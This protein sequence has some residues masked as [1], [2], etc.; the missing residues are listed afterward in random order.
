MTD[1]LNP[2]FAV[3][4]AAL[5]IF[6]WAYGQNVDD[7]TMLGA[8]IGGFNLA[9]GFYLGSTSSSGKSTENV[10]KAFDALKAQTDALSSGP[11]GAPSDPVSVT[12]VDK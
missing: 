11:T 4:L 2:K 3:A 12:E 10:G 8:I 1:F 5:L 9:L 7:K 6:A